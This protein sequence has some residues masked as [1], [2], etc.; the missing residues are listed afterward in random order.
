MV[1]VIEKDG[2]IIE[3]GRAT[4]EMSK[5]LG[6]EYLPVIMGQTRVAYLIMLW[7][8]GQD[9]HNRDI[10]I[11]I[12][13]SRAWIIGAKC[14][15]LSI[16]KNC[17][18]CRFLHKFKVKWKMADLPSPLKLPCSPFTNVDLCGFGDSCND[19]K[20]ATMKVW[21]V[22]FV[23]LNTKLLKCILHQ[24]IA[25]RIFS[26]PIIVIS[27]IRHSNSCSFRQRQSTCSSWQGSG[28]FLLGFACQ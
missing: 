23:R 9:H 16:C 22:L 5:F 7:A 1:K 10:A 28:R 8:H 27:V 13:N 18:R 24:V 17:V 15:A 4:K 14:I 21:N 6:R 25:L 20:Q 2:L 11:S 12:A 19:K 3:E 26:L